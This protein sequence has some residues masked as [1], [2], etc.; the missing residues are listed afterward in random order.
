L[1]AL[2]R[3][4]R[5]RLTALYSGLLML[6]GVLLTTVVHLLVKLGLRRPRI[7]RPQRD[8]ESTKDDRDGLYIAQC[9]EE[10]SRPCQLMRPPLDY[11]RSTEYCAAK[12]DHQRGHEGQRIAIVHAGVE[13]TRERGRGG[14]GVGSGCDDCIRCNIGR[15][16]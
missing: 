2:L 13:P 12:V 1:E 16:T 8:T 11:S 15:F 3:A 9:F 5:A 4:E 10:T 14:L 6:S 7:R